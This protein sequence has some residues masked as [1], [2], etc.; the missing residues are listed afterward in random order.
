MS[1]VTALATQLQ[2]PWNAATL[3]RTSNGFLTSLER[4]T[5]DLIST[6]LICMEIWPP[7]SCFI[8]ADR[9]AIVF[10]FRIFFSV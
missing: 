9:S 4:S 3:T 6:D 8:V 5:L 10:F 2:G 7:G 1:A